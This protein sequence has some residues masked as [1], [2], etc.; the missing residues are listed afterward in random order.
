M[1]LLDELGGTFRTLDLNMLKETCCR[2]RRKLGDQE[3]TTK[4]DE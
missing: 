3:E 1:G 2:S 4:S